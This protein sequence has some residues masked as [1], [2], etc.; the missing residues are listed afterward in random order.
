MSLSHLKNDI[1]ADQNKIKK[2]GKRL[3]YPRLHLHIFF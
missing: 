1:K 3:S 2:K